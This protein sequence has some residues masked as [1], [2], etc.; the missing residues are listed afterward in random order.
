MLTGA[1]VITRVARRRQTM[2]HTIDTTLYRARTSGRFR[3]DH[4]PPDHLPDGMTRLIAEDVL[5]RSL[6][7]LRELQE[8]L[9]AQD[10]WS[11]LIIMQGMDAAGKDSAIEH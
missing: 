6:A 10:E 1:R 5:A 4:H 2:R 11:L 8:R 9:Y 3:L 7:R